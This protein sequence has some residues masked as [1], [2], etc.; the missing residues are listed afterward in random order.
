M[1]LVREHAGD[2]P[3]ERARSPRYLPK[4]TDLSGY[5]QADLDQLAQRLNNRPRKGLGYITPAECVALTP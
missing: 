2:H 3:T 4:G 5:A 1:R